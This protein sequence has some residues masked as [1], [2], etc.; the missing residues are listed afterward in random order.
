LTSR[1]RAISSSVRQGPASPSSAFS[2][3]RA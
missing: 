3:I 1:S 2:K